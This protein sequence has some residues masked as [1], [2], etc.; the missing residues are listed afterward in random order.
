MDMK[1]KFFLMAMKFFKSILRGRQEM[2]ESKMKFLN[3][4]I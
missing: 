2:I 3:K 1:R 4:W